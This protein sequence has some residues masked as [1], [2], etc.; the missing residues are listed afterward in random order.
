[1]R[2][3]PKRRSR[4]AK[5]IVAGVAATTIIG[6]SA[7]GASAGPASHGYADPTNPSSINI[8]ETA[9]VSGGS[10]N[11]RI[12]CGWA[13]PDS[14]PIGGAETS[15]S[16]TAAVNYTGPNAPATPPSTTGGNAFQYGT[17]DDDPATV[18]TSTPC[19]LGFTGTPNPG[20]ATQATGAM[21]MIQV[22]PNA[23]DL[24]AQRRIE[25]WSAVDDT[26][27]VPNI[28][29]V[30]WD[31]YHPDGTLK[32]EVF[33]V[34]STSCFGPYGT[35][36]TSDP[37]FQEAINTGQLA[38]TA[39]NDANNGMIALCNEGVKQLWHNAFT[40]SKDQPNGVYKIVETAVDKDGN[41]T[42]LTY[43][44]DIIPFFDLAVDF[45]SVNYGA[46]SASQASVVPGDVVWNPPADTRPTVTNRGNSGEQIGLVWGPLVGAT[47]GKCINNFD[48]SL[49]TYG[50][51]SQSPALNPALLQHIVGTATCPTT[52]QL[53]GAPSPEVD[54]AGTGSQ[55]LC[56]N[57]LAKLDLSI[58]PQLDNQP[59]PS[60]TYSG[61]LTVVAKS[62][63]QV[64]NGCPTDNGSVYVP[65][66][67][68]RT[69]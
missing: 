69:S 42:Q 61:S 38:S 1:M 34:P 43:Y 10:S 45:N 35:S 60:D 2:H 33:G 11:T 15:N 32:F 3:I 46:I 48:A 39:V 65:N 37:M 8:P 36:T 50:P 55:L 66:S 16:N 59:P 28:S 58:D 4:H 63:I 57:D 67:G 18:P 68:T 47:H 54:F 23:D 51:G 14:N 22:L 6:L 53:A 41:S 64:S 26:Q 56:P 17:N 9:T 30:F 13:L 31:V 29:S 21:H 40:V 19:Q 62:S 52:A 20:S 44:L 7:Q 12:E 27:G 24:P 49:G 25:L 5:F